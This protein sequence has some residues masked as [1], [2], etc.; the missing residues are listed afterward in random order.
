M[1]DMLQTVIKEG[2]GNGLGLSNDMPSAGKTGTTN[3]NKD[4]WFVGYTPYYTTS[5]W[6]GY[7]M[8]KKVPGLSGAS[9]PGAIWHQ[10]M[11]AIHTGLEPKAFE[12]KTDNNE[13]EEDNTK[14]SED[15]TQEAVQVTEEAVEEPHETQ[16]PEATPTATKT[17]TEAPVKTAT[18][19]PVV[20]ETPVATEAPVET[21]APVESIEPTEAPVETVEPTPDTGGD[22]TIDDIDGQ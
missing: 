15:V 13:D 20:T 21:K 1:T 19:A 11:E 7:D 12:K 6:V 2:T 9:Y 22:T 14:K 8:P 5:V 18:P 16:Q 4:G 17:A 3:D 10:F